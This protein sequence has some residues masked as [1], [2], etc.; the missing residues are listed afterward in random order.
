MSWYGEAI[1]IPVIKV[2]RFKFNFN[3]VYIVMKRYASDINIFEDNIQPKPL[4]GEDL[5]L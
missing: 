1:D 5:L 2:C 4:Q 3:F